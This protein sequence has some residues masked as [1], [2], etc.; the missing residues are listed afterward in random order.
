MQAAIVVSQAAL[1]NV[2]AA[3]VDTQTTVVDTQA[4]S[5]DAQT[6]FVITPGPAAMPAGRA[7]AAKNSC[8]AIAKPADGLL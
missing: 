7:V 5:V 3:F 4:A 1:V 8:A 2:Q 6:T